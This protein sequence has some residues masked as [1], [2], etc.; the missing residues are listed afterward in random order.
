MLSDTLNTN[1]IKDRSGVECEFGRISVGPRQTEFALLTEVP[2]RPT[3]MSIA[4]KEIGSGVGMRRRSVV[5]FDRTIAGQVDTSTDAKSSVYVVADLPV[6]NLTTYDIPKDMIANLLSFCA[7]TGAATT[8]LFDGS[9]NG[10]N[11][12]INGTL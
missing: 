11:A 1:E 12:L 2:A 9:G 7:T 5:R 8:V 3:R 4:H 10:A 6:G